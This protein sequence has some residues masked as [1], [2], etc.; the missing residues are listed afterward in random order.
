M[1]SALQ[2]GLRMSHDLHNRVYGPL[3]FTRRDLVTLNVL[4]GRDI[5]LPNYFSAR[6]RFGLPLPANFRQ[7]FETVWNHSGLDQV[8][9]DYLFQ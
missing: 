4:R 7:A 1:Q 3:E 2:G 8:S 6:E 5:N 9:G